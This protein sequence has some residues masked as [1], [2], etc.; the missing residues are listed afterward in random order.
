MVNKKE[1]VLNCYCYNIELN[2]KCWTENFIQYGLG[3]PCYMMR[4]LFTFQTSFIIL[5][6]KKKKKSFIIHCKDYT[7]VLLMQDKFHIRSTSPNSQVSPII[8][9]FDIEI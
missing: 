1:H 9:V 7:I 8:H 6:Q 3:I 4:T 5:G 2:T